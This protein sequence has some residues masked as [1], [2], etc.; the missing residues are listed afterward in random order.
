ML[1][2]EVCERAI[3]CLRES[4]V[5]VDAQAEGQ[6]VIYVN[7]AFTETTGYLPEEVIGRNCRFM[8]GPDTAPEA[9]AKIRQLVQDGVA[10]NVRL[11][12]YRKDG[13]PFHNELRITPVFDDDGTLTHFIGLQRD[14]TQEVIADR[15]VRQYSQELETINHELRTLA[16]HDPLTDLANRRYFDDHADVL[17]QSAARQQTTI[18]VFMVD[19]DYF[20]QYNDHYGHQAGDECL[21][22]V[23]RQIGSHVRSRDIAARY[24]GEEFVVVMIGNNAEA[25]RLFA[26]RIRADIEA[27]AMPHARSAAADH[28]TISVGYTSALPSIHDSIDDLVEA[29]DR[30]LYHAKTSGR[31]AASRNLAGS[32]QQNTAA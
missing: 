31:N 23:G 17:L 1:K 19:V 27:L 30:A 14:V 12:N 15:L 16:L 3:E 4:V 6:P 10:G 13:T 22:R 18:S 9:V 21:T 20:K 5:I 7:D 28:V 8:Q 26:E 32:P 25:D 24:G 2:K 11:L 29:A